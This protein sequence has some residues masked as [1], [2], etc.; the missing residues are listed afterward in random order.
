[1]KKLYYVLLGTI[2]IAFTGCGNVNGSAT[3]INVAN[4]PEPFSAGLAAA[5]ANVDEQNRDESLHGNEINM[6]YESSYGSYSY[7]SPEYEQDGVLLDKDEMPQITDENQYYEA[8]GQDSYSSPIQGNSNNQESPN[9][10]RLANEPDQNLG[11]NDSNSVAE[12]D[13]IRYEIE[14]QD[15]YTN[16]ETEDRVFD[17]I[18]N[19]G[20]VSNS[21]NAVNS[22]DFV[23]NDPY[24]YPLIGAEVLV[25]KNYFDSLAHDDVI[26]GVGTTDRDGSVT[27]EDTTLGKH[28][29]LIR[30]AS[31]NAYHFK[32]EIT[33]TVVKVIITIK[34]DSFLE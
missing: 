28:I 13:D 15:S 23:I 14:D 21:A 11:A 33:D 8:A 27:W 20:K 4:T 19:V 5:G 24:G 34:E 6:F 25:M 12:A 2:C 30:D 31:G 16:Y 1:M 7:Q 29:F 3:N 32:L 22:I 10:E 26:W 18:V 17:C 9:M